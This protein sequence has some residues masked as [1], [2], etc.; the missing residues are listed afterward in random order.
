MTRPRVII[1]SRHE[2]AAQASAEALIEAGLDPLVCG[3][4]GAGHGCPVFDGAP[5]ALIERADAVV[6]DLDLDRPDDRLVLRSLVTEHEGLPIA[7]ERTTEE[8]RRHGEALRPVT[9]VVPFSP[10]HTAEA[11]VG[12]LVGAGRPRPV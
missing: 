6:Y 5:C 2:S 7:S 1:E 12:A 4:P 11:M 10:R 9:V 3:G 8:V